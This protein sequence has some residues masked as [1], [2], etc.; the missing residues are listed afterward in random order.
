MDP[1]NEMKGYVETKRKKME[2]E[3]SSDVST[4]RH[5]ASVASTVVMAD[6]LAK[7]KKK[8][9]KD[10]KKKKEEDKMAKLEK[11][12]AE[13]RQ[14]EEAERIRSTAVMKN[15]YKTATNNEQTEVNEQEELGRYNNQFN[16]HLSR[17]K[18]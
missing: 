5:S 13:R 2:L 16:P 18:R 7:D 8:K 17:T 14:R 12:R 9:K 11:M 15:Y 6:S 10:K 1:L 4:S 3:H